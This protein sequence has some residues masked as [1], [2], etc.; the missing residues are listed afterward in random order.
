MIYVPRK[1]KVGL[2]QAQRDK[3]TVE[4]PVRPCGV[5]WPKTGRF[6]SIIAVFSHSFHFLL[7]CPTGD[8][9]PANKGVKPSSSHSTAVP[10]ISA[11]KSIGR[12]LESPKELIKMRGNIA[13]RSRNPTAF[14]S[15]AFATLAM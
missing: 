15:P 13:A 2:R 8:F 1:I 11:M 3:R 5:K 9:R 12:M 7:R 10:R 4:Y 6:G 14:S